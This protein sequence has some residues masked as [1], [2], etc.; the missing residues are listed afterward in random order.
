MIRGFIE[1]HQVRTQGVEWT[2]CLP[3][4]K[5][6]IQANSNT[7]RILYEGGY[8]AIFETYAE[9]LQKIEEALG[10]AE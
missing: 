2:L 8:Y 6:G 7:V 1:V 4:D 10:G 5:I 3:I 9:V